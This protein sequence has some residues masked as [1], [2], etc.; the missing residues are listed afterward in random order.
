[1]VF[2]IISHSPAAYVVSGK[3]TL[4][5]KKSKV[6]VIQFF[7]KNLYLLSTLF[8]NINQ[9]GRREYFTVI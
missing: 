2:D 7:F 9:K 5:R 4:E 8:D 1:M 3:K 6:W